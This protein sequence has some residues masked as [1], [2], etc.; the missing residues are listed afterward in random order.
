MK[1]KTKTDLNLMKLK[2]ALATGSLVTTMIG[3][4]VLGNAVDK[5]ADNTTTTTTAITAPAETTNIDTIIPEELN[6]NLEAVPTV[7]APTIIRRAPLTFG[8]SSG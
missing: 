4:G 7:A 6:L 1:R 5:L 3:V 2:V 8:R